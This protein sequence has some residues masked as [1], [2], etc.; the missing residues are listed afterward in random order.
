MFS[1]VSPLLCPYSLI[2]IEDGPLGIHVAK[3]IIIFFIPRFIIF[4]WCFLQDLIGF[5]IAASSSSESKKTAMRLVCSIVIQY[6]ILTH[7]LIDSV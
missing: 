3:S 7:L 2:P 4:R 5:S 1:L 6:C